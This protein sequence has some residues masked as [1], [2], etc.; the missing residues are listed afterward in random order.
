[1]S[2]RILLMYIGA[3]GIIAAALLIL[4]TEQPQIAVVSELSETAQVANIASTE[5]T[6]QEEM[7]DPDE[8]VEAPEILAPA[9][10]EAATI[11]EES[12]SPS[13]EETPASS[14]VR[15]PNPY[16]SPPQ[17]FLV[18]N[19]KTRAAL[20]NILCSTQSTTLQSSS[21]SGVIIDPRGIILT[22]AHVAQYVLLAQSGKTNLSCIIRVG[23]PA[24]PRWGVEVLYIPPIWVRE[25]AEDIRSVS[26]TGTGEHDYAL[27]RIIPFSESSPFP[28]SF[29][30]IPTDT[31]EGIG[32][33]GDPIL[34]A[35]Y[36]SEFVGA[37]ATQFNL[38]PASSISTV[39]QLLT[40]QGETVDLLSLG[41]VPEAQSGS[42]GGA[43]V[44]AWGYLIG[45]ITTTSE[46][47]TTA[48][49]ELRALSLSYINGDLLAQVGVNLAEF[50]TADPTTR[51]AEFSANTA[52][53]LTK[54]L[55]DE[56]E[57]QRS[58]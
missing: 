23:A 3:V 45:I 31:R 55:L 57:K 34:A 16:S 21:G 28:A 50:L 20:V 51:S 10:P 11:Q 54:L 12:T 26:P 41:G 47:P 58:R 52:P 25:H 18:V 44:N 9:V 32:F 36:P 30:Y 37:S 8:I 2:N 42:S 56:V 5:E 33:P 22:N 19:E 35:S 17:S 29:P 4:A 49:R 39:K 40:F 43:V 14:V 7:L 1:M 24:T 27:L 53:A 15:I 6:A 48:D 13:D 38:H 46:G